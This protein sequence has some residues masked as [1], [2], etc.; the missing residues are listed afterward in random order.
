MIPE[1]DPR[2]KLIDLEALSPAHLRE[3]LQGRQYP[4]AH[5][6]VLQGRKQKDSD[7]ETARLLKD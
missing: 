3:A 1:G 4:Q 7:D 2:V 5:R 6:A